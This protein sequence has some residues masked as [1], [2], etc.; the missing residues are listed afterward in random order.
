MSRLTKLKDNE[1]EVLCGYA[2]TQRRPAMSLKR[3]VLQILPGVSPDPI[4]GGHVVKNIWGDG[5]L[6]QAR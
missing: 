5:G 6:I 4:W 1:K 3:P 2:L